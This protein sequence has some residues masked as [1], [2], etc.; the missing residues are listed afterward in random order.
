MN[1]KPWLPVVATVLVGSHL[2]SLRAAQIR[3]RMGGA[4]AHA[5]SKADVSIGS[6]GP[7]RL[8][9]SAFTR[10][11]HVIEESSLVMLMGLFVAGVIGIVAGL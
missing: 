4:R 9:S 2:I 10:V 8:W 1:V 5:G 6:M 11:I 3:E 7:S